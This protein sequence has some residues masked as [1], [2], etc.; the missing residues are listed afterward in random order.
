M[1]LFEH[2][3]L[4]YAQTATNT[5]FIHTL[6]SLNLQTVRSNVKIPFLIRRLLSELVSA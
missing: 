1:V 3:V 5:T 4:I 6:T 2:R